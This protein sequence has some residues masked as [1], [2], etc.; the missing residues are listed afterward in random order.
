MYAVPTDVVLEASAQ[1]FDGIVTN[2]SFY[3]N[4]V[5]LGE[6]AST[7]NPYRLTWSN[8]PLGRHVLTAV[9]TDN[10]GVSRASIPVEVFVHAT[11]GSQTNSLAFAPPTVDLTTEGAADWVHWGLTTNTSV[12]RKNGVP[13]QI[14]NFTP[15]GPAA[16]QRYADNFTAFAWTDGMPT[17]ATPGTTSGVFITGLSNGFALTAPADSNSRK[18]RI[19]VGAY[20]VRGQLLAYLSD[21][22]ARPYIDTSIN[23]ISWDNEYAVYQIDYRAASAGQQL[24]VEYRSLNL[25]DPVY[26]NVTLQAATLQGG[27][28]SVPPVEIRN[29]AIIGNDFM[30]SFNTVTSRSYTVQYC[31]QLP[32][33]VWTNLT[34]ISGDGSLVTVTNFNAASGQRYY[35]V[36]TQ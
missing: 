4:A 28:Q 25:L 13:A 29:P 10:A 15:V 6:Q 5:K 11:S 14:S 27:A 35:R 19:Y 7:S 31:D 9:A 23:D 18:L 12:D 16:V 36:E 30:L 33:P 26:G 24:K 3:A 2:V 20:A 34:V 22:S 8:A 21:F 17:S 32:A 1:D